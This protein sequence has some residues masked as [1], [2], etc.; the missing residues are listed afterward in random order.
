MCLDRTEPIVTAQGSA[1]GAAARQHVVD[2]LG[3]VERGV[4]ALGD[5]FAGRGVHQATRLAGHDAAG[6]RQP[7]RSVAVDDRKAAQRTHRRRT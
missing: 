6:A 1:L 7:L 3:G 2:R 4:H 5:A